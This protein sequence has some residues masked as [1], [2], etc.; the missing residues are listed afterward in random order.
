MFLLEEVLRGILIEFVRNLLVPIEVVVKVEDE[1]EGEFIV[2][3]VA[4][5]GLVVEMEPLQDH[6]EEARESQ[7]LDSPLSPYFFG[8][9]AA[10]VE[11]V[12]D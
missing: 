7:E 6:I 1:G 4:G 2:S 5:E 8:A 9:V 11:V 10:I 12:L 3:F